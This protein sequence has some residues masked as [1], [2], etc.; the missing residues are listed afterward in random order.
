MVHIEKQL[1]V[2]GDDFM[3]Q[4]AF[5]CANDA[6]KAGTVSVRPKLSNQDVLLVVA[7]QRGTPSHP[8]YLIERARKARRQLSRNP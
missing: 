1:K 2:I 3:Q 8:E 5:A 6:L 7:S 4:Q